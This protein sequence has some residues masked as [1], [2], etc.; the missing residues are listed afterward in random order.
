MAGE[1]KVWHQGRLVPKSWLTQNTS[2][3]VKR[4]M[5]GRKGETLEQILAR[6]AKEI[7]RIETAAAKRLTKTQV[8]RINTEA[9]R[10]AKR[11][12]EA[13]ATPKMRKAYEAVA[14]KVAEYDERRANQKPR[15]HR[16]SGVPGA[17][18]KAGSSCTKQ[19]KEHQFEDRGGYFK[20]TVCGSSKTKR[21]A[22]RPATA[23]ARI[24]VE[25]L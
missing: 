7:K 19:G 22:T 16:R 8:A 25:K 18:Y 3:L 20:C 5:G 23:D 12:R 9:D 6:T 13:A 4:E 1:E 15:G 24:R 2:E 21:A 10:Q 17:T 14:K 11:D